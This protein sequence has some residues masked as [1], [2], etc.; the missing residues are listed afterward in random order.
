VN[1]PLGDESPWSFFANAEPFIT[2]RATS[3][4][5]LEGF[6][7]LRTQIGVSREI[8]DNLEVSLGYLRQQDVQRTGRT[9][10]AMPR[11]WASSCRSNRRL[12]GAIQPSSGTSTIGPLYGS[13]WQPSSG[14]KRT[15]RLTSIGTDAVTVRFAGSSVQPDRLHAG[16]EIVAALRQ[17]PVADVAARTRHPRPIAHAQPQQRQRRLRRVRSRRQQHGEQPQDPRCQ[18]LGGHR[19]PA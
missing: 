19:T 6:S 2:L 7:A 12:G 8:N 18:A 4:T 1:V 15:V 17:R 10:S 13:G 9:R 11:S 16:L 5:G 3:R 14:S